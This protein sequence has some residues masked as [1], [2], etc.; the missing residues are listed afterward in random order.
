M[1]QA[2]ELVLAGSALLLTGILAGVLSTRLGAPLLLALL[3]LGMAAGRTGLGPELHDPRATYLIGCVA[4]ALILFDGGLH[5]RGRVFRLAVAPA[6]LLATLGSL[7][8]CVVTGAAATLLLHL[9]WLQGGLIGAVVSSTD[10]AAVFLL[11]HQRGRGIS[12]RIA[13]MLETEAGINDPVA[14]FLTVTLV[15]VLSGAARS[16]LGLSLFLLRQASVGLA[17]GLL[18]A[19]VLVQLVNRLQ[20][21]SGLY[22]ILVMAGALAIF[23]GTQMLDGSGYLAVYVAGILCGNLHLRSGQTITRFHEAMGWLAQLVLFIM[24]GMMVSP[25]ALL[26]NLA[27]ALGISAV[28]A[29]VARPLAVWLSLLPFRFTVQERLFVSWVGLRGAVPVFM[30][31]IPQFAGLPH[32][33]IYFQVAFVVVLTSLL[34]QGWTIAPAA[35]WLKLALPGEPETA[36]LLDIDIAAD[37]AREVAAWRVAA[38][39]PALDRPFEAL[40][41]H[42][43]ATSWSSCSRATWSWRWRPTGRSRRRAGCSRPGR[44]PAPRRRC[45]AISRSI[46][47]R[48]STFWPISTVFPSP[49]ARAA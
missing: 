36:Q 43:T 20:V 34:F 4:I 21:S 27:A 1:E 8:T 45:S 10:A 5:T 16:P 11:L 42:S 31:M 28:L 46:P 30:A 26:P 33:E 2:H 22:P 48:R 12:E 18:G 7:V 6:S 24:L 49:R 19:W 37:S 32:S 9:S 14:V 41:L 35:R 25:T 3:A 15:A 39:S 17:A 47:T 23:G 13:A 40:H 38:D 29:L 44:F